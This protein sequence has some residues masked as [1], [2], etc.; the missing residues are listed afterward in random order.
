[1][2]SN[3]ENICS[4]KDLQYANIHC[5]CSKIVANYSNIPDNYSNK[6]SAKII[7]L[8]IPEIAHGHFLSE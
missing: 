8:N 6:L 4:K 7:A 3:I 1:M 5:K 2:F